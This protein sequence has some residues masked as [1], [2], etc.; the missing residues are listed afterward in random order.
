MYDGQ[1]LQADLSAKLSS[2]QSA[3][4]ARRNTTVR[5][6]NIASARRLQMQGRSMLSAI[7]K[8][9]VQGAVPV[10]PL[11][12]LGDE[13]ADLTLHGG[14]DKAV[15]AYP[16][17]HYAYWQTQRRAHSV[18]LFDEVLAPGFVGENLTLQGLLESDVWI[19]D[20]LHFPHCILRV[21]EPRHPCSKFNAV[22]G[23]AQASRDMA[24]ALC[25]GF[26]LAVDVSGPVEAGEAFT[27]VPGKRGLS[28]AEAF[29]AKRAKHLR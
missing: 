6:V 5:S 18:S 11:G 17:E 25:S 9:A 15:Y 8:Q 29:A 22:M 4:A 13:Q 19:G 2:N 28:V 7:G 27:V 23:Y 12:L 16:F 26:Y 21:T 14:L 3:T 20:E 10:G 24:H 1:G